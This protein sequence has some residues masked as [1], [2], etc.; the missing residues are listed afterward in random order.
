ML[1]VCHIYFYKL[2]II[3]FV[4]RSLSLPSFIHTVFFW[5]WRRVF[6]LDD[7]HFDTCCLLSSFPIQLVVAQKVFSRLGEN[8]KIFVLV[9]ISFENSRFHQH[10][11]DTHESKYA[12][13]LAKLEISGN[14]I[15]FTRF[16]SIESVKINHSTWIERKKNLNSTHVTGLSRVCQ[17]DVGPSKSASRQTD[18]LLCI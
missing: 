4:K 18:N 13:W 12:F 14:S 11:F 7:F 15:T 2:N 17:N 8:A 3:Q 1:F 10:I 6:G 16:G 9:K 5:V